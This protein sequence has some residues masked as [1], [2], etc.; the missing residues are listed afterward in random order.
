[1]FHMKFRFVILALF[2]HVLTLDLTL[3]LSLSSPPPLSL[4]LSP[5]LPVSHAIGVY[6][7]PATIVHRGLS[8]VE[9]NENG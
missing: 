1:M 4:S 9:G 7:F 5:S 6:T 3:P 8:I 2:H